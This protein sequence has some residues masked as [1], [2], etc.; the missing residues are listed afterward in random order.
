MIRALSFF[1]VVILY[2]WYDFCGVESWRYPDW[3]LLREVSV[4]EKVEEALRHHRQFEV[5][6][7]QTRGQHQTG[8]NDLPGKGER[9]ASGW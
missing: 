2:Q 5:L 1:E 6:V 3:P 7:E 8:R 9:V 4:D